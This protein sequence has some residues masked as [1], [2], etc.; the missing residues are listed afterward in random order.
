MTF[1]AG[2]AMVGMLWGSLLASA[3]GRRR[4]ARFG[5][6]C[7]TTDFDEMDRHPRPSTGSRR[8]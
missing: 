8:P 1:I 7:S 6:W 2:A 4:P 3:L 5:W